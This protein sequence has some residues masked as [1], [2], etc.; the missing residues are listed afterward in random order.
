MPVDQTARRSTARR[1]GTVAG[2]LAALQVATMLAAQR[3]FADPSPTATPTCQKV[4]LPIPGSDAGCAPNGAVVI[5]G[6]GT[7]GTVTDP[8]GSLA[9]GCAQAAAWVVRKLSGAIDGTTA[10][11][12]TNQSFLQQYAV[13]F[14]VSTVI[15]LVLWLLAVTKRA[16]RGAPLTT[17]ISEAVGFLWLTVVASAFTPLILFTV[18]SVTDGLTKAIA[19]GTKSDTGTYLS[20]FADTLEKGDVGGGPLILVIVSLVA[21]LAAAVLWIELVIRAAMLYVGALLG[22]AV[23]AGLVDRQLWKHVRRWAGMML[24]VDLAKPIIVIILGLAGAVATGAGANDDFARVLSGLAILFLSIFASAAVYRFVPTFGDEMLNM[25]RARASAVQAG[26]AMI[27]GTANL[28]KQGISTHGDRGPQAAG[29]G[30]G[31]GGGSVA[32]G[33]AAHAGRTPAPPPQAG[34]PQAPVPIR[35]SN[36]AKGG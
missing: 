18:V 36:P 27:N 33:I 34:P 19:V 1:A 20:G 16:V 32:P 26:S 4:D 24:A 9:K 10:V 6:S 15:T 17:A 30:G 13:V 29:G 22:T 7:V 5:P 12:F 21:V 8:L 14:A 25:R 35:D 28:M 11:D 31:A 2:A 3:V 23:Y